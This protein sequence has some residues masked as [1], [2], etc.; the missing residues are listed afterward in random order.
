MGSCMIPLP[1]KSPHIVG[2]RELCS[3]DKIWDWLC[4]QV[5]SGGGGIMSVL[6]KYGRWL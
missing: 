3:W 5:G 2:T 1:P 6:T 4:W